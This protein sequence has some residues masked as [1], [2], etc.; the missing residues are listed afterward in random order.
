MIKGKEHSRNRHHTEKTKMCIFHST[1][2]MHIYRYKTQRPLWCAGLRET[3]P[4]PNKS[5]SSRILFMSRFASKRLQLSPW[6]IQQ[7]QGVPVVRQTCAQC[8]LAKSNQN[9]EKRCTTQNSSFPVVHRW[10]VLV[11]SVK[12]PSKFDE[13]HILPS[14]IRRNSFKIV[15]IQQNLQRK[16][17]IIEDT[18]K[19]QTDLVELKMQKIYYQETR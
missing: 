13:N 1:L 19:K 9:Y 14:K 5:S 15:V 4:I 17:P 2:K 3:W 7:L 11:S 10:T 18:V 12:K 6:H 16:H 8:A